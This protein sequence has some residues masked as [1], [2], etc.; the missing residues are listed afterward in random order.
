M[1]FHWRLSDS[2]SPQVSRTLLSIL[3]VLNNAVVWMVSTCLPT[4]KSV[5]VFF[6]LE[7]ERQQA[8][9]GFQDSFQYSSRSRQC[10]N[11]DGL[12]P[13]SDVPFLK[14]FFLAFLDHSNCAT[15]NWYHDHTHV[16]RH[17]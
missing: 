17:F 12:N 3:S 8:S 16:A 14:S 7:S 6:L 1:V 2:K 9:S 15:H 13:P 10:W 11:L 4:S 5:N